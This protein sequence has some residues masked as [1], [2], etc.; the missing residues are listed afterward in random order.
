MRLVPDRATRPLRQC[1]DARV[2]DGLPAQLL[3]HLWHA[4][5]RRT[6]RNP[7]HRAAHRESRHSRGRVPQGPRLRGTS[8]IP[9]SNSPAHA[10]SCERP[11]RA[12]RVERIARPGGRQPDTVP[13]RI[14]YHPNPANH[15]PGRWLAM[16]LF[17]RIGSVR[18]EPSW[19]GLP[20]KRPARNSEL[21]RALRIPN[22]STNKTRMKTVRSWI[23]L[24]RDRTVSR[25]HAMETSFHFLRPLEP[26]S[27][28]KRW[29]FA[30]V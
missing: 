20:I 9:R 26:S 16:H 21:L 17:R 11:V 18:S 10:P 7:P 5:A 19:E 27:T 3:Q 2:H 4:R 25:R 12:D 29:I 13:G 15:P 28:R 8:T 22:R 23:P 1:H 24:R 30:R 6:G 14:R